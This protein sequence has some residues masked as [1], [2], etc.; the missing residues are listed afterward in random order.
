MNEKGCIIYSAADL[1]TDE[2]NIAMIMS[3]PTF[4]INTIIELFVTFTRSPDEILHLL[5]KTPHCSSSDLKEKQHTRMILYFSGHL[6]W[7]IILEFHM[8]TV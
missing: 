8:D 4:P 5:H 1:S 6:K 7:A 3:K 2:E